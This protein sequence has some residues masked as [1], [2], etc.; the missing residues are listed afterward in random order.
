[1]CMLTLEGSV[2]NE[3]STFDDGSSEVW[4]TNIQKRVGIT[5]NKIY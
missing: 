4:A 5:K 1:M 3:C 2:S